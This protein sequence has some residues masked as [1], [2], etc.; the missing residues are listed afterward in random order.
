MKKLQEQNIII[1]YIVNYLF[2]IEIMK[3]N[4]YLNIIRQLKVI[5]KMS[6]IVSRKL[7]L[8]GSMLQVINTPLI[9]EQIIL[10]IKILQM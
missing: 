6:K 1:K 7:S 4:L 3:N 8:K 9:L 10:L 2:L 5:N